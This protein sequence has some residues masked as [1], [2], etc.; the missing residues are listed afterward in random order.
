MRAID[1]VRPLAFEQFDKGLIDECRWLER[2]LLRLS[3]HVR[4]RNPAQLGVYQRHQL[5][6]GAVIPITEPS[7]KLRDVARHRSS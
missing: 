6:P 2:V 1:E 4:L 7:E 5:V 3:P